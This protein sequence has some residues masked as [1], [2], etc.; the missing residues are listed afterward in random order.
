MTD[1]LFDE[2][3]KSKLENY[4][5]GVPIQIWERMKKEKEDHKGFFFFQNRYLLVA[6]L[7]LIST[8]VGYMVINTKTTNTN[9]I[10]KPTI[11]NVTDN[12]KKYNSTSTTQQQQNTTE[13]TN[14][15]VSSSTQNKIAIIKNKSE[16][17]KNS[18]STELTH[19][20]N[21]KLSTPLI[22]II[23][24][25]KNAGVTNA[26]RENLLI[27]K[28]STDQFAVNNIDEEKT[29]AGI[30]EKN[31]TI[32]FNPA[33]SLVVLQF[34]GHQKKQA[35]FIPFITGKVPQVVSRP[36]C[37]TIS[38]PRRR[39]L[40]LEVYVSPDYNM[41]NFTATRVP[42]NYLT[43]RKN[44]ETYR[45]SFS[46]GVRL[47]KNLGEKT[48]VKGG[49]NYSQINEQLK[50]VS[51][52]AKQTTQII[53]IRTVVRAPGDTLFIRDTMYFEQTGTKYR[54]TYN[55][56]RFIDL[57]LIFS[58]E[59]GNP[60]LMHFSVNAGPIFNIAS[61]YSG[62]VLDTTFKPIRITTSAGTGANNWRNNIGIGFY[63]SL[64]IYK[65]LNDRM[66]L[67]GEPYM[68]YNFNPVTQNANII[69]QR[70]I[71]TGMQLGIRYNLLKQGQR[72]R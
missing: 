4:N 6:T 55:R 63:A 45:T 36:S 12:V 10:S 38:G 62:E 44:N 20:S 31:N 72:Y 65:K 43:E 23:Q 13:F 1:K 28:K 47:V 8:A 22:Q 9:N 27:A 18:K 42:V 53:T 56:Y 41:R 64:S 51:E 5:S 32:T 69:K 26:T 70:Y 2:F 61:I 66:H 46:A 59:F 54:T 25:K 37:P 17:S 34:T 49:I 58:Y 33:P 60:D 35:V 52:N 40:F 50:I 21:F 30:L 68:R 3:V 11:T 67:F 14:V 19:R 7:L 39:D 57:P 29:V 71:I 48:L 24:K 15:T 16:L